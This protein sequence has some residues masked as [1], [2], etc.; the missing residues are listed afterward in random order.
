MF[1][2]FVFLVFSSS[3]F[4]IISFSSEF[5]CSIF[6]LL[7]SL[8]INSFSSLFPFISFIS[9]ISFI[10]LLFSIGSG[11]LLLL[12]LLVLDFCSSSIF[13]LARVFSSF[14]LEG[15][16]WSVLSFFSLSSFSFFFSLKNIGIFS[17]FKFSSICDD[18]V[19]LEL[20]LFKFLLKLILTVLFLFN[21]FFSIFPN[22][23]SPLFIYGILEDANSLSIFKLSI[24]FGG[25]FAFTSEFLFFRF[26]FKEVQIPIYYFYNFTFKIIS[27]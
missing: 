6:I 24:L 4:F 7:L 15:I 17:L 14:D 25:L 20:E 8:L 12:L 5:F 21:S 16:G 19:F 11:I 26:E 2:V 10:L 23:F 27:F 22:I 3:I 1:L 9:F 18:W 13:R